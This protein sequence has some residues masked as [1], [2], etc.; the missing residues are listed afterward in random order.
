VTPA[1]GLGASLDLEAAFGV[2]VRL[3]RQLNEIESRLLLRPAHVANHPPLEACHPVSIAALEREKRLSQPAPGRRRKPRA[4]RSIH[5]PRNDAG[6]VDGSSP[7]ITEPAAPAGGLD[8]CA[9]HLA[10][11]AGHLKGSVCWFFPCCERFRLMTPPLAELLPSAFRAWIA[12]PRTSVSLP[13][14]FLPPR[15]SAA[16]NEMG[17][18]LRAPDGELR[19][20]VRAVIRLRNRVC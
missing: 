7:R 15:Q 1:G 10:A 11:N 18:L 5:L 19:D 9:G 12:E 3:Y 20:R 13:C 8:G 4:P 2:V 6:A 17:E 14:A 16:D